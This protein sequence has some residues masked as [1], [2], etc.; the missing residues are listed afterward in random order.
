MKLDDCQYTEN[1]NSLA[2]YFFWVWK[3]EF[4][5]CFHA[6]SVLLTPGAF[7]FIFPTDTFFHIHS[8][9][10]N[11]VSCGSVITYLSWPR[12]SKWKWNTFHAAYLI[13]ISGKYFMYSVLLFEVHEKKMC[14]SLQERGSWN[15]GREKNVGS[16]TSVQMEFDKKS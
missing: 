9:L 3:A 1:V 16:I 10:Q 15:N 6:E 5:L 7:W 12:I 4:H 11:D 2:F 13:S 14:T 8:T